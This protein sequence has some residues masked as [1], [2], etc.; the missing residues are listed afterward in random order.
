ML[1]REAPEQILGGALLLADLIGAPAVLVAIERDKPAAIDA[2]T[3]AASQLRD[4]RIRIVGIPS[5]YPAGGERQLVALMAG[6]EVPSGRYPSDIGYPCQNV[7]TAHAVYRW[8]R[9]REPL[10]SRIVTVSGNGVH[11]PQNV[12]VPIGSL[13]SE[14]IGYCQGYDPPVAR[15][16]LGGTMMGYAVTTDDLPV[17]K[18]TNCIVA[19]QTQEI[20][21]D[22]RQWPCIRCG[23][24]ATACPAG[25]LPQELIGNDPERRVELHLADCIECGCCDV[26]CP[27]HIP[28]T[29][30]L[31]GGKAELRRHE[32]H[33]RL[34]E[35]AE[36]RVQRKTERTRISAEDFL[37]QQTDLQASANADAIRDAVARARQQRAR[38]PPES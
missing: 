23:E 14:L 15:L 11:T 28:I 38:T 37:Q 4:A 25:L 9:A 7:G 6:M 5:I 20:H 35:A 19:A 21:S 8:A 33:A 30:L 13:V 16:I 27:S 26:V 17:T 10:M 34:A 2:M 32:A 36:Q 12:A 29:Q 1:M 22:A 24:C 18:S 3:A 31:R